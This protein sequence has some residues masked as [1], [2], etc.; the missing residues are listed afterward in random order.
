MNINTVTVSGNITRDPE[1]RA[2]STGMPVVNMSVAV[3]M[4]RRNSDGTWGEDANFFN[5]VW[6][7]NYAAKVAENMKKG[8]HV[9][10]C[11]EL[12]QKTYTTKAGEQRTDIFIRVDKLDTPY[13]GGGST[14]STTFIAPAVEGAGDLFDEDIPF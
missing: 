6:F 5:L 9:Q 7:G 8:S 12:R 10:V 2:T 4:P 1:I 11:G 13:T 3:N 14:A